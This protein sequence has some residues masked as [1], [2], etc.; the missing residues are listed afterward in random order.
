MTGGGSRLRMNPYHFKKGRV[1]PGR[2]HARDRLMVIRVERYKFVEL[3]AI[4]E[5]R[6]YIQ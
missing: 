2:T 4:G 5:M 6:Y 3:V 1:N